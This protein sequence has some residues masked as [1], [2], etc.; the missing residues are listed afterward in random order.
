M[1]SV[2][3]SE[4]SEIC[5]LFYKQYFQHQ[6]IAARLH[7]LLKKHGAKKIL[8][9]GG[10]VHVARLLQKK[11]YQLYFVDYTPEMLERARAVLGKTPM[12]LADMRS[13]KLD[14]SFDAVLAIGRSFTY[15]Y[16][17]GDASKA[18]VSF[19]SHLKRK[20]ILIIDNYQTGRIDKGSYFGGTI[21]T[22]H[23][24]LRINR[25][26]KIV[27]RKQKPTLY[28]WDCTYEKVENGTR[29]RFRDEGHLLRSF[30]KSEIER[31][32]KRSGLHFI[33]HHA[34]F[35]RKSFITEAIHLP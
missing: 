19:R 35:E 33:A 29:L 30:T 18:L 9:I 26:S 25:I 8:F 11:G 2:L 1:K 15:M 21:R 3:Y 4:L 6:K 24:G 16:T 31:L 32:L 10:L 17:D 22:K 23:Q 13:L 20:G 28:Q 12:F 34:N 7:R 14:D 5:H 27:R